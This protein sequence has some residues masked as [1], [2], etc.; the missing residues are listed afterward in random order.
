MQMQCEQ[1][2]EC[3]HGGIKQNQKIKSLPWIMRSCNMLLV[4]TALRKD[5]YAKM[6]LETMIVQIIFLKTCSRKIEIL[7]FGIASGWS[8]NKSV[9][10]HMDKKWV[11]A[12]KADGIWRE[13]NTTQLWWASA[14]KLSNIIG[15]ALL[16][17]QEY[18]IAIIMIQKSMK[19]FSDL[20]EIITCW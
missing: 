13:K 7:K 12:Y 2:V 8:Y 11:P 3:E 5:S 20:K 16:T 18:I 10:K 9:N 17:I 6:F 14:L 1:H 15:L 19:K 4:L